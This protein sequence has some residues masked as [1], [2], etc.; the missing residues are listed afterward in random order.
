[1]RGAREVGRPGWKLALRAPEGPLACAR[2]GAAAFAAADA[3]RTQCNRSTCTP[4]SPGA[5][6]HGAHGLSGTHC[7]GRARLRPPG[8]AG[9]RRWGP[10]RRGCA[11]AAAGWAGRALALAP[12]GC[13]ACVPGTR[14]LQALEQPGRSGALK[15][16]SVRGI[17]FWRSEAHGRLWPLLACLQGAPRVWIFLVRQVAALAD[18]LP[19]HARPAQ[20]RPLCRAEPARLPWSS[21]LCVSWPQAWRYHGDSALWVAGAIV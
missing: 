20:L 21:W 6:Q 5:Q 15:V 11:G 12:E 17:V 3:R 9:A 14:R 8:E 19:L 7:Q 2:A 18:L 13:C 16:L 4:V 1:M 10:G